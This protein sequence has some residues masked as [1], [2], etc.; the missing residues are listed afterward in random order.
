MCKCQLYYQ[1]LISNQVVFSLVLGEQFSI[2]DKLE[3]SS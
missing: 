3:N 1:E 2:P